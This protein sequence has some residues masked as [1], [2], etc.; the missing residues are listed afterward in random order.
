VRLTPRCELSTS[1]TISN[2]SSVEYPICLKH[3]DVGQRANKVTVVF[4]YAFGNRL[5]AM[6]LLKHGISSYGQI[7]NALV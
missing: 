3:A 7:L 4:I 5:S 1:R 2:F 6:S